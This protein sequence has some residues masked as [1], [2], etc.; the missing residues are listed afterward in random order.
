MDGLPGPALDWRPAGTDTNS[1]AVLITY[2]M[3][4]LR[5]LMRVAVGLPPP[6][7]DREAEFQAKSANPAAQLAV[8]DELAVE[9]TTAL[10]SVETVDWSAS[11]PW[12]ARPPARGGR[13]HQG[14]CTHTRRRTPEGS[15]GPGI[16]HPAPVGRSQSRTGWCRYLGLPTTHGA[17]PPQRTSGGVASARRNRAVS[18][19]RSR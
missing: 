2:S 5:L 14:L 15:R 8:I 13:V 11:E 1:L 10:N 9:T 7:R 16:T 17:R 3:N 4:S 6:Q 12:D 19:R 18:S